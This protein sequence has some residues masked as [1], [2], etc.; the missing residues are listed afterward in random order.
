MGTQMAMTRFPALNILDMI[1]IAPDGGPNSPYSRAKAKNMI[2][3]SLDPVAL[4]FWASKNVLMPAAQSEGNR[5]YTSMN[6]ES[7]E[8]GSFGH[9]LRLSMLEL[10]KAGFQVTMNE[11]QITVRKL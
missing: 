10:Q 11:S 1:W 5:R 4:D 6:P 2:A 9:W 8:P 3:A 7:T